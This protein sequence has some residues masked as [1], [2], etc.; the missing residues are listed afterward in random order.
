M[1]RKGPCT[2]AHLLG[3][4]E[5]LVTAHSSFFPFASCSAR[6]V[7][8]YVLARFAWP[9]V[10]GQVCGYRR[11]QCCG[12]MWY[13]HTTVPVIDRLLCSQEFRFGS[14]KPLFLISSSK[15]C[16]LCYLF[17]IQREKWSYIYSVFLL[18]PAFVSDLLY[19]GIAGSY[20]Y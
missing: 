5:P 4:V 18:E 1:Q 10:A 8:T 3:P 9:R 6:H 13:S 12:G 11:A 14:C 2:H 15:T 16:S 17:K 19:V 20:Y 7:G